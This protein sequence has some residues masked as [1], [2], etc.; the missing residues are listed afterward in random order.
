MNDLITKQQVIDTLKK[1]G[2]IKEDDVSSEFIT[3]EIN[4]IPTISEKE[5]I[6]KVFERVVQRLR[7]EILTNVYPHPF[8]F[9]K[10]TA[11]ERAIE[12]VK[13]ECGVSE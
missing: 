12:I 4:R 7:G 11:Y 10:N 9:G 6:R 13:E 8:I 3:Y 5:I 1:I 2:V